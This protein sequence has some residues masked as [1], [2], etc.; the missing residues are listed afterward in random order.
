MDHHLLITNESS[1]N[2]QIVAETVNPRPITQS[3]KQ[4]YTYFFVFVK[5][6]W[7][8]C[9]MALI[10]TQKL[11]ELTYF[12][13][14]SIITASF[15]S[16]YCHLYRYTNNQ[17]VTN[18]CITIIYN[19]CASLK[20]GFYCLF[21][22]IFLFLLSD[23][24]NRNASIFLWAFFIIEYV[25][26]LILIIL[27]WIIISCKC[28]IFYPILIIEIANG[29]PIQIGATDA[30]LNKLNYCKFVD[31]KL[32]CSNNESLTNENYNEMKCIICQ[33]DYQN[34]ENIIILSCQHHYH[35]KCG[36]DWL[37]I[38]KTCPICRAPVYIEQIDV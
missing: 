33:D 5:L 26:V 8:F 35:K 6:L 38:N 23:I 3:I 17:I 16:I 27:V 10:Y 2:D 25:F 11:Q 36:S 15:C 19:I 28:S 32:V 18:N 20:T 24:D 31:G 14:V 1:R 21:G 30:E 34:Y 4:I 13:T 7:I 9:G 12:L 29:I 37:K 22:F